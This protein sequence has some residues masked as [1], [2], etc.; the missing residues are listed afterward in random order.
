MNELIKLEH[1]EH[2]VW[3]FTNTNKAAKYIGT[4]ATNINHVLTGFFK[5]IKGWSV[6]RI[7]GTNIVYKYINPER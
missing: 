3:Y 6:E 2:G 7:D 1:P 5:Q 4:S